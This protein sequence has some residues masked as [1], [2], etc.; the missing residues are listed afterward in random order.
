MTMQLLIRYGYKAFIAS[1]IGIFAIYFFLS[2]LWRLWVRKKA[3]TI[4]IL[5][6]SLAVLAGIFRGQINSRVQDVLFRASTAQR[7]VESEG[8]FCYRL[9]S[10]EQLARSAMSPNDFMTM[11]VRGWFHL[12]LEPFPWRVIEKPKFILYLPQMLLWYVLLFF[13]FRGVR[14]SF[15]R[16]KRISL[17]LLIY[18]I[19]MASGLVVVSGNIGTVFRLRDVFSPLIFIFASGAIADRLYSKEAG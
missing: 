13:A 5:L 11:V 17:F 14:L 8:G 16:H 1:S 9:L 19:I 12:F 3:L 6:V 18:F 10:D 7:G 4:F 15:Y 2:Y